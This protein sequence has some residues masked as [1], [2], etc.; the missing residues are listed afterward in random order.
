MAPF[1]TWRKRWRLI[2]SSKA[3]KAPRIGG[4]FLPILPACEQ[5]YSPTYNVLLY[6]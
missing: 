4:V 2:F 1:A 5:I 6:L 3:K